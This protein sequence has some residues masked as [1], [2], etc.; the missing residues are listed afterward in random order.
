MQGTDGADDGVSEAGT[1]PMVTTD[2]ASE[3]MTGVSSQDTG[4]PGA[5]DTAATYG[6]SSEEGTTD[7]ETGATESCPHPLD[8]Y[9]AIEVP[10]R[11]CTSDLDVIGSVNVQ[12]GGDVIEISWCLDANL[13]DCRC[14]SG[15]TPV[16]VSVEDEGL[17][18]D[19]DQNGCAHVFVQANDAGRAEC[20]WEAF[21]LHVRGEEGDLYV[22]GANRLSI[23]APWGQI[24][25]AAIDEDKTCPGLS[26]DSIPPPGD[27]G[28]RVGVATIEN[29]G[30]GDVQWDNSYALT[31]RTSHVTT[32]CDVHVSWTAHAFIAP[33]G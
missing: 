11:A 20:D 30:E 4:D 19:V 32:E 26:C 24:Y 21:A 23:G 16:T 5:T 17:F 33:P 13:D 15:S 14:E 18:S 3:S 27:H 22:L 9:L 28:L 7:E 10:G 12:G 1:S 6:G 8:D 31:N 29:G 25:E 2:S